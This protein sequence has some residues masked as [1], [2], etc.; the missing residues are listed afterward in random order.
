MST[1]NPIWLS[2]PSNPAILAM[3]DP[4]GQLRREG[5]IADR[6]PIVTSRDEWTVASPTLSFR[7]CPET[8]RLYRKQTGPQYFGGY[9]ISYVKLSGRGLNLAAA[10]LSL[11]ELS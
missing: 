5:L 7:I 9:S 10:W 3:I 6:I 2:V 4:S 8:D 11:A 1:Q